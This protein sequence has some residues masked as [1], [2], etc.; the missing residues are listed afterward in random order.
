LS[1][2]PTGLSILAAVHALIAAAIL[3]YMGGGLFLAASSWI[4]G[5]LGR[6]AA[7]VDW[8]L[9]SAP[10]VV[11]AWFI[12]LAVGIWRLRPW[13][14]QAAV[15]SQTVVLILGIWSIAAANRDAG[16]AVAGISGSCLVWLVGTDARSR[17][18]RSPASDRLAIRPLVP[19]SAR[20]L[21]AVL[22]LVSCVELAAIATAPLVVS[23]TGFLYMDNPSAAPD[24]A[25]ALIP[26]GWLL[27]LAVQ[28]L[29]FWRGVESDAPAVWWIGQSIAGALA[30]GVLAGWPGPM[31]VAAAVGCE[32]VLQQPEVKL[33]LGAAG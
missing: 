4:P 7:P 15:V 6:D 29:R 21:A 3:L 20:H 11:G 12:V 5:F 24:F 19:D 9:V 31:F 10:D 25:L 26:V 2:R 16:V 1:D 30:L 27:F 13:A 18:D 32:V 8:L 14:W 28:Q 23:V 33:A 17:L 22:A